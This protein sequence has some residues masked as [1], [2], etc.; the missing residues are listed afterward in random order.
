MIAMRVVFNL[1]KGT[2]LPRRD[3]TCRV[4][5]SGYAQAKR[6]SKAGVGLPNTVRDQSPSGFFVIAEPNRNGTGAPRWYGFSL[7]E[8]GGDRCL[9]GAP[10]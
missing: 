6:Q 3:N 8:S 7:G 2:A 5:G 4:E 9:H 1:I 10:P